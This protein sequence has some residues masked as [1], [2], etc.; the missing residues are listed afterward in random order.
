MTA[1]YNRQRSKWFVLFARYSEGG[2]QFAQRVVS[3]KTML[4]SEHGETA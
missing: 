2:W 1:T 4:Q 3:P